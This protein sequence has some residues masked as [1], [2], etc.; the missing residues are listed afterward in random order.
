MEKGKGGRMLERN[1]IKDT[2]KKT[3]D[4]VEENKLLEILNSLVNK[5][6]A[7]DAAGIQGQNKIYKEICKSEK[8]SEFSKRE[9]IFLKSFDIYNYLGKENFN[10]TTEIISDNWANNT[11]VY[12]LLN[13]HLYNSRERLRSCKALLKTLEDGH[14]KDSNK[15]D[16]ESAF[17]SGDEKKAL[18]GVNYIENIIEEHITTTDEELKEIKKRLSNLE[19]SIGKHGKAT[20]KTLAVD[21][22]KTIAIDV[23]KDKIE[24]EKLLNL[25][26][27]G[28]DA[29]KL[30][31]SKAAKAITG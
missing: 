12:T 22:V 9:I 29:V 4:I 16:F 8:W 23:I 3:I 25:L 14:F 28:A 11:R 2:L 13:N 21:T 15:E 31:A 1:E 24:G 27:I 30:L 7:N 26:G 20:W 17:I 5:Y 18:E 6:K 10:F 19:E